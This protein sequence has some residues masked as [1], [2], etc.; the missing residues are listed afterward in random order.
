MATAS[1]P[2]TPQ[3][4][5]HVRC[6]RCRDRR[7]LQ[8]EQPAWPGALRISLKNQHHMNGER[9]RACDRGGT[10]WAYKVENL[11][12]GAA[13]VRKFGYPI[14]EYP[15]RWDQRRP[16]P[17]DFVEDPYSLRLW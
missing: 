6:W 14:L 11:P 9:C 2:L 13:H 8:S 3:S 12:A 17:S 16:R 5:W 15:P 7:V 1:E 4:L 10:V